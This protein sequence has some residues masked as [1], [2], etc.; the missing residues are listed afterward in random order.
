MLSTCTPLHDGWFPAGCMLVP[1]RTYFIGFIFRAG[2]EGRPGAM[3]RKPSARSRDLHT[4]K[5]RTNMSSRTCVRAC[6]TAPAKRAGQRFHLRGGAA[7]R[8]VQMDGNR[9]S[10]CPV[11][12]RPRH[13]G[14][15][16]FGLAVRPPNR[17]LNR[18]SC[19]CPAGPLG[20]GGTNSHRAP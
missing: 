3:T 19:P 11:G 12:S 5:K 17:Q 15:G 9:R 20:S 1:A 18:S 7:W 6:R 10:I 2:K 4:P 16:A 13:L 8:G 14:R